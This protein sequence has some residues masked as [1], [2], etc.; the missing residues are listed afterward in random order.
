MKPFARVK[1]SVI[2][3]TVSTTTGTLRC[4]EFKV[5][6]VTNEHKILVEP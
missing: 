1:S 3:D 6:Y 5:V 2:N 4:M